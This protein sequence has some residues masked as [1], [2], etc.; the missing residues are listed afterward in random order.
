[1]FEFNVETVASGSY[2]IDFKSQKTLRAFLGSCVGVVLIDKEANIGGLLHILLPE[3]PAKAAVD[4]PEKYA[5]TAVPLFIEAMTAQG[6][7]VKNMVAYVAGGS[8]VGQVSMMDLKLDIGG[9]SAEMVEHYLKLESIK[10]DTVETGGYLSTQISLD[11]EKLECEIN[12]ILNLHAFMDEPENETPQE[13]DIQTAINSV[14]PIPQ[15]ALKV[16]RMIG[17]SV[18]SMGSIAEE[19]RKDQVIAA[20]VL[21]LSNSA[22]VNPGKTIDSIDKALILLGEK[23]ILL[24]TLSVFTEMFYQQADQGYSLIK[25]GLFR[26]STEISFLA[27]RLAL[28]TGKAAADTAF[29]A[30]LLH[31]IGKTVLDQAMA[32]E[33]PLF[34]RK[35]MENSG[36]NLIEIEKEMF[37]FNH[38]ETGAKLSEK[39]ALPSGLGEAISFHHTPEKAVREKELTHLIFLADILGHSYSAGNSIQSHFSGDMRETFSV[40]NLTPTKLTEFVDSISWNE[41]NGMELI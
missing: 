16:I 9:K 23:R 11:L 6:A 7:T 26:H 18:T 22:Y 25:G 10:I 34:Y 24:L 20:K 33:Y 12:P 40:L 39:W 30:G 27:E 38:N 15:I 32:A 21:Q 14:K 37:G 3:P 29:T 36:A 2:K 1:M 5:S 19:I 8:L 4:E 13:I 35:M 17:S 41:L 31:D 28:F